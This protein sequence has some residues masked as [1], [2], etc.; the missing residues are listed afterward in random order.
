MDKTE[1]KEGKTYNSKRFYV[2]D[3][4]NR[5]NVFKTF[6]MNNANEEEIKK[7]GNDWIKEKK[8]EFEG[9]KKDLQE[10]T[11]YNISPFKYSVEDYSGQSIMMIGSTRSG[12]STVLNYLM[13]N[14]F[15]PKENKFINILMSNSLQAPTYNEFREKKNVATSIMFRPEIIKECYQINS[16]TKNHYKFNIILDD[17]VDKKFDK[18]LM[19]LL[20]IYRNSKLSTI[21][22]SQ[23]VQIMN[24]I[25]R[26]NINHVFLFKLNSTE[27]IE[28]A[29]KCYLGGF[30][31]SSF[32]MVDKI[33]KYQEMTA[34]HC[35]IYINNITGDIIR[36]KINI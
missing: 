28:K 31:P 30:F 9:I 4:I 23:A 26:T 7:M 34:D 17:I 8:K 16:N 24:S 5:H 18:E 11:Q 6:N 3:P 32:K 13:D 10:K 1:L 27:Q 22:C 19:K 20:T 33:R 25:G 36:T 29:I 21:I 12:K 15:M 14:F 2:Y 35:F